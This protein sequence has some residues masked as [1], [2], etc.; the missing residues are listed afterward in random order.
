MYGIYYREIALD[1]T[2]FGAKSAA[3]QVNEA[4]N[5]VLTHCLDSENNTTWF[6]KKLWILVYSTEG[7]S[8]WNYSANKTW[9]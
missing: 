7:W 8:S 4:I 6:P 9:Y 2:A 5:N 1:P 3:T